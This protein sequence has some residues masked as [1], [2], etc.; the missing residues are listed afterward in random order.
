MFSTGHTIVCNP[1]FSVGEIG[2][3]RGSPNVAKT[4]AFAPR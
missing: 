1:R 3:E 2:R 4:F